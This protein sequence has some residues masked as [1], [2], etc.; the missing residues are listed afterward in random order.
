MT[1]EELE[2]SQD[3]HFWSLMKFVFPS[4]FTF[5]FIAVYQMVDG[6]F[7]ET[8]V[9]D[10]AISAVNLY[11]PVICL[12]IAFGIMLG[13]GGNAMMVKKIGEGKKEEASRIFSGTVIFSIIFTL[14]L[15]VIFVAFPDPIMRLC[16]ATDGNIEYLRPYYMVLSFFAV[17]VVLQSEMGILVIGEGKSVVAA[18]VIMIGGVLNCVLDYVFMKYLHMGIMGAAIATVIGYCST[19][20]YAIYYYLISKK[21]IYTFKPTKPKMREI[22][23]ISF[24][25]SSDMISNL[26]GGVASLIMNH[27]ACRYYGEVGVSALSIILY[28]NF[29][30]EAVFM[31]LTSAVEPVF[32]FHYG[33]GNVEMRKRVFKLSNLWI[34]IMGVVMLVGV[35]FGNEAITKIFFDPG[36][37]IYDIT[38]LG[39]KITVLSAI[40]IGFNTFFSGLFTAFSNGL[41]S[42]LLSVIR[43]LVIMVICLLLFSYLFKGVGLWIAMPVAEAL[44]FVVCIVFVLKYKNRYE[45]M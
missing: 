30:L 41:I 21:S 14:V 13:T 7:I 11:Y 16:G 5:V 22:G 3:F 24:N 42:G 8:F 12:F 32:S 18:I 26:V 38:A 35:Y 19:V 37:E 4:I 44:S 10:L 9:D 40:F 33:A 34:I 45:Y 29:F 27:I 39:I 31:G 23:M 20:V 36:T 15:T 25:G 1:E 28:L 6:F 2:L 43:S 17:A